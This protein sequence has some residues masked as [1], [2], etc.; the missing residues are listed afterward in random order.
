MLDLIA[1]LIRSSGAG[2]TVWAREMG[3]TDILELIDNDGLDVDADTIV[4]CVGAVTQVGGGLMDLMD[5]LASE[6]KSG[7]LKFYAWRWAEP[8]RLD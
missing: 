7:D 5:V 3:V 1:A 8:T 6:R 4:D 2:A